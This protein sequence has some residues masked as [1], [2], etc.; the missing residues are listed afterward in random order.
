MALINICRWKYDVI[1]IFSSLYNI[2]VCHFL[3]SLATSTRPRL[4]RL[5]SRTHNPQPQ[6]CRH[7]TFRQLV[8]PVCLSIYLWP[9]P[10]LR[11]FRIEIRKIWQ[12]LTVSV[13]STH[14]PSLRHN[15]HSIPLV[16]S[17]LAS[18]PRVHWLCLGIHSQKSTTIWKPNNPTPGPQIHRRLRLYRVP[19][20]TLPPCQ[21]Q[22]QRYQSYRIQ[23]YTQRNPVT[24]QFRV[25]HPNLKNPWVA[26]LLSISFVFAFEFH[27]SF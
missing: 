16:S 13:V 8:L 23:R 4:L 21:L 12:R 17:Q 5:H 3:R 27:W 19:S 2:Q 15:R 14:L 25:F 1:L 6:H 22:P 20:G 9:R 24:N 7:R 10:L 18:Q 26:F 11:L